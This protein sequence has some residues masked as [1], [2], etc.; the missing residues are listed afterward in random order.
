LAKANKSYEK[1][2]KNDLNPDEVI[3]INGEDSHRQ[4]K[5]LKE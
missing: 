1:I 2:K 4:Y 3:Y 5:I